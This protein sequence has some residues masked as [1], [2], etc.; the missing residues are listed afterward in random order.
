MENIQQNLCS[1]DTLIRGH[2][3][4]SWSTCISIVHIDVRFLWHNFHDYFNLA[5][6]AC[7]ILY[8]IIESICF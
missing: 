2:P 3:H 8:Y 4:D 7:I 6:D 5:Q 1:R